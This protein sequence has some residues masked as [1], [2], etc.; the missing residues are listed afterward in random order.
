MNNMKSISHKRENK[1][2]CEIDLSNHGL[3]KLKNLS[4]TPMTIARVKDMYAS[5]VQTHFKF[6]VTIHSYDQSRKFHTKFA[7]VIWLYF[8]F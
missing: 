5:F 1:I 3:F 6:D 8:I 4:I 7:L 2:H